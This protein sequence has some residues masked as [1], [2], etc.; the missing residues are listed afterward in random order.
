MNAV[1]KWVSPGPVS[2]RFMRSDAFVL[3]IRGPFGSGKSTSCVVKILLTAHQ[4]PKWAD[5]R[6]HSRIAIIRNTYTELRST[7]MKTWH[8]WVPKNIGRWVEHG[9]PT[10][11]IIDSNIDM[12]VIFVSLDRP[13]DIKKLLGMELTAAWIN[14][15]REIDKEI[16]DALTGRVG[17][18]P[19]QREGGCVNPQ[20]MMDTN[21]PEF[22]HWWQVLAERDT[23]SERNQA[24]VDSVDE[25][26]EIL[27]S[28][29]VLK[30]RQQLFEFLA[31]ADGLSP[32]AENITNLP[33][34]YYARISAG[35]DEQWVKV[36][37]RNEYGFVQDGR[38][39]YP[40][41]RE[42]LHVKLFELN[43]RLPLSI[44]I[45]FGLTPAATIGQRSFTGIQRVRWE[46][47]TERAGARQFG[48]ILKGFL[49][50]TC[51]QFTIGSITGD[52]AGGAGAQTD[53]EETCFK[54]LRACGLEDVR[55]ARTNDFTLRRE[56]HAAA[57]TKII[58]GNAGYQIHPQGCPTLR[59]GMGGQYRYKRVATS[60]L[61]ER[62]QDRPEKNEVSHVC[63]ADQYRMLGCGEHKQVTS[64]LG[65]HR[66]RP[67]YSIT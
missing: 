35:K 17:R 42:G 25:A 32:D 58:D 20:I 26:Q 54:I 34:G 63:E 59:R 53:S 4:Q 22:G 7:T 2:D 15:A 29:G 41:F 44:G 16:I 11:H 24:L 36:Y 51:A 65:Q 62:F 40:E 5:G 9:P 38:P 3:G 33:T 48:E 49:N 14:E 12:E 57:M 30:P 55:G 28:A 19:A 27:R 66:S 13:D 31:Q 10:H 47:V 1:A 39:V 67:A 18:F 37:V 64:R 46:V 45:D 21:S 50:E 61:S 23:T 60:G 56:A 52:P 8:S 43:P 6:R